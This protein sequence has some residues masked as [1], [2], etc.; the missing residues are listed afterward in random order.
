MLDRFQSTN[1]AAL[2][3]KEAFDLT[4]LG[5]VPVVI[6][7]LISYIW[8]LW[9]NRGQTQVSTGSALFN[10]LKQRPTKNAAD[11]YIEI[12][13]TDGSEWSGFLDTVDLATDADHRYLSLSRDLRRRTARSQPWKYLERPRTIIVREEECQYIQVFQVPRI[14]PTHASLPKGPRS[15]S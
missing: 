6:A 2:T 3:V 15:S 14:K 12:H 1:L 5:L 10:A 9:A 8:A 4:M 13:L 11:P 7:C